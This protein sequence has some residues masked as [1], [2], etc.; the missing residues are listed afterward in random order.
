VD[1]AQHHRGPAPGRADP[2]PADDGTT[3]LMP[4]TPPPIL[5]GTAGSFA[6]SVFHQR[7]SAL[8]ERVLDVLP[9]G[10]A[11]RAAIGRLLAESTHGVLEPVIEEAADRDRWLAWGEGLYGRPWGEAPFLWAES[12]WYRR[13]LEATGYFRPGPWRG[14]DPFAP[15]KTAELT[16]PAVAEHLDAL[17]ELAGLAAEK[18]RDVLLMSSLWGNRADLALQLTTGAGASDTTGLLADDSAALWA[19]LEQADTATVSLVADNA[20]AEL[21]PDLLL[22]D[23]LLD[24]GLAGEVVVWV[25]PYPYYVSDAT[26]ADVAAVVEVL[27]AAPVREANRIGHRLHTAFGTGRLVVRTHD[28]FCAPLPFAEMPADLAGQL[29]AA[30]VVVVKGDL[31]YRRLVGDYHWPAT[32]SFAATVGY[33]PASVVALRTLK[34]DVVVGLAE[35]QVAELDATGQQWRTTGRYGLI[36]AR[37]PSRA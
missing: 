27:R 19:L 14:V 28:F 30:T 31:N 7:H 32:T 25:K 10:P 20:G 29:R 5:A 6:H 24:S 35:Q 2:S 12:F 26:M 1:P 18:K 8:V 16:G 17:P 15:I 22:A 21:L 13:L 37:T 3:I 4:S 9:Y 23:H 36:Q 33:F 34:S 11:Q